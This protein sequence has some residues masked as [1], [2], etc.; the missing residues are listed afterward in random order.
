[1]MIVTYLP[2][3]QCEIDGPGIRDDE[4]NVSVMD[5]T[6][7]R[8][9]LRVSKGFVNSTDKGDF[10]PIGVVEVDRLNAKVLIELPH[11]ADSGANRLWIPFQRVRQEEP[12]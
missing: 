11:E 1:M 5:I 12:S 3:V 7:N 8:H 2:E 9:F 6:G 10:L 4:E